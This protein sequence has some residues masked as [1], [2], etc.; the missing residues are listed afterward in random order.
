MDEEPYRLSV[1]KRTDPPSGGNGRD[2]EIAVI[3]ER[4][5]RH[6]EAISRWDDHIERVAK[7]EE[8]VTTLADKTMPQLVWTVE[9]MSESLSAMLANRKAAVRVA[10]WVLSFVAAV[11]I[12]VIGAKLGA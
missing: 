12:A 11:G 10:A 3:L 5:D 9:T 6:E 8:R 1:R 4:L 2:V 7:M